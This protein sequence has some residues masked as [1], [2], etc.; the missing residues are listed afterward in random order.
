MGNTQLWV[1]VESGLFEKHGLAADVR[2]IGNSSATTA[3]LISG[4]AQII[5]VGGPDAISA[6]AAGA[7]VV[8]VAVNI[9]VYS[10][11]LET[12]PELKTVN[13]IKGKKIAVDSFGS[14][15]DIAVRVALEKAGIDPERDVSIVAVGD[16]PTRS[17]ALLSGAVQGTMLNPPYTIEVEA[18][19]YHPLI[20]LAAL[21]LPN[22]NAASIVQRSYLATHREVV[23]T[24]I[25]T[26]I[27]A[28]NRVR[29]DKPFT[30]QVMSK[31]LKISDPRALEVT[32]DYY[33]GEVYAPA[34]AP[35]A[36]QFQDAVHQLG[37]QNKALAGFDVTTI[38][39]PTLVEDAVKR[40]LVQ[41]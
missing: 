16:V 14:P 5:Q 34:P 28:N 40:G 23:Q 21:K 4:Q 41:N 2:S 31:Y 24:Y 25:D 18:K 22:A 33:I 1:G 36:E 32:Y 27:E 19:G 3:A 15:P 7:D 8:V 20:D 35:K 17:A 9:P 39:D 30:M 38:L 26:L 6:K 12:P 11:I 29:H 13:D 10:Y 37:R